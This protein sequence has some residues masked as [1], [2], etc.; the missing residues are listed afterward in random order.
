MKLS[1]LLRHTD[2]GLY[3]VHGHRRLRLALDMVDQ[4][5]VDAP[6]LGEV[7]IEK[8]PDGNVRARFDERMFLLIGL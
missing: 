3:I 4:L 7:C 5:V 1:L 8:G 6:G 2:D